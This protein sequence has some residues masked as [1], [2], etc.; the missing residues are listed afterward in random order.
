MSNVLQRT[1]P[2]RFMLVPRLVAGL[3]LLFFGLKHFL[4]PNPFRAI[5]IASGL[6]WS[7]SI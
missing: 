6:P 7:M 1:A 2:Y 5:L 4:D 3:P